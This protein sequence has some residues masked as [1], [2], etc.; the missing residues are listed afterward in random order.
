MTRI[1]HIRKAVKQ[2]EKPFSVSLATTSWEDVVYLLMLVDQGAGLLDRLLT[3]VPGPDS[4][5]YR[6]VEI[7]NIAEEWQR[8]R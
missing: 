6:L 5:G 2:W 8:T 1:E 4:D 3:C 7:L